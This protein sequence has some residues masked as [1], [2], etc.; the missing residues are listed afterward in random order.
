MG[1]E[2]LCPLKAVCPSEGQCQGQKSGMD[3][4]VSRSRGEK[5]GGGCFSKGKL[6]KGKT[7]EM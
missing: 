3:L 2:A 4:L 1:G 5:I 6:G 7:L